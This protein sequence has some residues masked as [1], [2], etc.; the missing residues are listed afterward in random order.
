VVNVAAAIAIANATRVALDLARRPVPLAET[1][2]PWHALGRDAVF[3]RLVTSADG[4]SHSEVDRRRR[5]PKAD[6]TPVIFMRAVAG[7]LVGPLT[8]VLAAGATLSALTGSLSDAV[9]VLGVMGADAVIGG[10]QR[11]RTEQS[12]ARLGRVERKRVTVRREGDIQ[13]VD[14]SDLVVGDRASR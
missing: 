14:V 10:V 8:P 7:E 5:P 3:E 9:L 12:I 13:T 4:L 11:F 6:P 1:A 2:V